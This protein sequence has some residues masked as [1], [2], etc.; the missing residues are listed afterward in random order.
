MVLI[1]YHNYAFFDTFYKEAEISLFFTCADRARLYMSVWSCFS[2]KYW[3]RCMAK[4]EA[5]GWD[6]DVTQPYECESIDSDEVHTLPRTMC[7]L[8]N[9]SCVMY[10]DWC[11]AL[12]SFNSGTLHD[13]A[14]NLLFSQLDLLQS[15][16][17]LLVRS[18]LLRL[19]CL[20][21]HLQEDVVDILA[22]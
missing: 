3:S 9:N 21:R 10:C 15:L 18:T 11:A 20:W 1:M 5:S 8:C 16:Q 22:S 13:E 14:V 19:V 2:F 17:K 6:Q 4:L 12:L 7:I